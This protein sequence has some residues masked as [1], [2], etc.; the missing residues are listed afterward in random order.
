M[1]YCDLALG[2]IHF[3][4]KLASGFFCFLLTS[5][6]IV[7]RSWSIKLC[8]SRSSTQTESWSGTAY[9]W[10]GA[11]DI[12]HFRS[13][14]SII[15]PLLTYSGLKSNEHGQAEWCELWNPSAVILHFIV[16]FWK[17]GVWLVNCKIEQSSIFVKWLLNWIFHCCSL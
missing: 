12:S 1:G 4:Q 2:T 13:K 6:N 7:K 14:L 10:S 15:T 9:Q 5:G 16:A 17:T 8:L 3:R 11:Q